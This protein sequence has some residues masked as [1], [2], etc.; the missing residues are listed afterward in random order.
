MSQ[1]DLFA[2]PAVVPELDPAYRPAAL[3]HQRFDAVAARTGASPVDIAVEQADGSIYRA[4]TSA[5]PDGHPDAT[6]NFLNLERQVKFLL[7]SR[8]GHRIYVRA[9]GDLATRL[10]KHYAE[11]ETGKF[12]TEIMGNRIF[13]RPFEVV[14]A[15]ADLPAET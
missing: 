1:T 7:W 14:A 15:G 5:L 9:P 13:E 11:T 10:R 12:D 6:L 8:G 3:F 2:P 4:K